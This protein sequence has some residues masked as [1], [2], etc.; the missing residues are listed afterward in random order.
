GSSYGGTMTGDSRW[1]V[2]ASGADNLVPGDTNQVTDIFRHDMWTGRTERIDMT[3]VSWD[4]GSLHVDSLGTTALFDETGKVYARRSAG[5]LT[6][7]RRQLSGSGTGPVPPTTVNTPIYRFPTSDSVTPK[8]SGGE[9]EP[10]VGRRQDA[11]R[12]RPAAGAVRRGGDR[13]G[14]DDRRRDLRGTGPGRSLGRF[15]AAAGAGGGRRG[16]VL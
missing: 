5:R 14:G 11:G 8:P 15:R 3:G 12:A 1:V 6:G 7:V 4:P 9:H 13:P 10:A 2:F 16:R